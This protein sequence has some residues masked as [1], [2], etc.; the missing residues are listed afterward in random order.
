MT[1]SSSDILSDLVSN[2]QAIFLAAT[3]TETPL[4]KHML[5]GFY[6]LM[7]FDDIIR[8]SSDH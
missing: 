4:L 6:A 8:Y 3:I 2:Q 7:Q 1:N 5:A